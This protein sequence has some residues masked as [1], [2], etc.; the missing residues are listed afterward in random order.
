M[1]ESKHTESIFAREPL[2]PRSFEPLPRPLAAVI[3]VADVDEDDDDVDERL[4]VCSVLRL[5]VCS[6]VE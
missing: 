1:S 5:R 2:P 6:V 4:R 3:A